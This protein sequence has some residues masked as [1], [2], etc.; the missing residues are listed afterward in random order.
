MENI[1]LVEFIS[2][3]LFGLP[4]LILEG[5]LLLYAEYCWFKPKSNETMVA[6]LEKLAKTMAKMDGWKKEAKQLKKL[7]LEVKKEETNVTPSA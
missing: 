5:V 2:W 7:A 3:V 1:W 4:V 6:Q